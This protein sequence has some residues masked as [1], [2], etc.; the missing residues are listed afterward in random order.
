MIRTKTIAF[1]IM[2]FVAIATTWFRGS[3]WTQA[4]AYGLAVFLTGMVCHGEL[5]GRGF[6][7]PAGDRGVEVAYA[8]L[9]ASRGHVP[10]HCR[11]GSQVRF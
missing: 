10:A 8:V 11:A 2:L 3:I 6:H 5:A 7:R 1:I 9:G 4:G